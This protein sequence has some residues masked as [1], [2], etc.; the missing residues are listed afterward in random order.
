M[1]VSGADHAARR[2]VEQCTRHCF[3]IESRVNCKLARHVLFGERPVCVCLAD[4][5]QPREG[6]RGEGG[7]GLDGASDATPL[8]G[9]GRKPAQ[10]PRCARPRV[11]EAEATAATASQGAGTAQP[12]ANA[13]EAVGPP[14][15]VLWGRWLLEAR[16]RPAPRVG[17]DPT[18]KVRSRLDGARPASAAVKTARRLCRVT[19]LNVISGLPSL[20]GVLGRSM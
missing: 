1:P 14:G 2:L 3:Q 4:E 7:W 15:E 19:S 18:N 11:L 12:S 8:T 17:R 5:T 16:V 6:G 20:R 9:P 13:T 10:R